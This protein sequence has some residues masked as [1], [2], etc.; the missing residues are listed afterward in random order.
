MREEDH[1]EHDGEVWWTEEQEAAR[2]ALWAPFWEALEWVQRTG[3]RVW[4]GEGDGFRRFT[5]RDEGGSGG[6]GG[7]G[8]VQFL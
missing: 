6:G 7:G 2:M 5:G 1:V 3:V 8:G 4:E